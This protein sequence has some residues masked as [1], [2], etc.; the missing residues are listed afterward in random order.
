MVRRDGL[1]KV[2]DF[3]LAKLAEQDASRTDA[4]SDGIVHTQ[5]GLTVGT[6]NYMSPE[7]ALGKPIDHRTDLFS[8]GVVLYELLTG[9]RP[10]P[11][12]NPAA[13]VP[14]RFEPLLARLLAEEPD[15][16]YQ[17]A[18]DVLGGLRKI[19]REIE[20]EGEAWFKRL[21][22]QAAAV[23][24]LALGGVAFGWLERGSLR[25]RPAKISSL[26]VLPFR[27]LNGQKDGAFLGF[28]IA[29]ELITR[30]APSG[31]VAVRPTS[32]IQRYLGQQ[33][34][35][36]TAGRQL[37]VAAV[38]DGS[39]Q[40]AGSRIRVS[41]NLLRAS[42]GSSLWAESIDLPAMDI[43]DLAKG[44]LREDRGKAQAPTRRSACRRSTDIQY[45]SIRVLR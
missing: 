15:A 36:L 32:A 42:D 1:I 19:Q 13:A 26:A 41:A 45:G 29:N 31:G 8:L 38:L 40:R 6:T 10:L 39:Y 23:T 22:W 7:Q 4:G 34:D 12:G 21:R 16:R 25:E 43:L 33:V 18:S 24:I 28:G 14:S 35:A 17:N 9:K 2:L 5:S 27:E 37:R 20:K 3:G 11:V 44:R 30:L